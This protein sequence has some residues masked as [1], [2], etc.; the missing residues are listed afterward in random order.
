MAEDDAPKLSKKEKAFYEAKAV[1]NEHVAAGRWGAAVEAY[2]EAIRAAPSSYFVVNGPSAAVL[3]NRSMAHLKC[4]LFDQALQDAT[5]CIALRPDWSK[6]YFRRGE[7]FRHLGRWREA[8]INF[9]LAHSKDPSDMYLLDLVSEAAAKAVL[10]AAPLEK[11]LPLEERLLPMLYLPREALWPVRCAIVGFIVGFVLGCSQ[12]SGS[13]NNLVFNIMLAT[14]GL[15]LGGCVGVAVHMIRVAKRRDLLAPPELPR[16]R[17][18]SGGRVDP[19]TNVRGED[20]EEGGEGSEEVKRKRVKGL[21]KS[22]RN[23]AGR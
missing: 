12:P 18:Q 3:S 8:E 16:L 13:T 11:L 19:R 14:G 22:L 6:A 4:G 23:R 9:R 7:V 5:H 17:E 1:G 2:N 21:S 15:L 20:G 10:S